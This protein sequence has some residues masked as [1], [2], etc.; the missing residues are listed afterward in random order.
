MQHLSSLLLSQWSSTPAI[1]GTHMGVHRIGYLVRPYHLPHM[2]GFQKPAGVLLRDPSS[3]ISFNNQ[4]KAESPRRQNYFFCVYSE[5]VVMIASS[6]FFGANKKAPCTQVVQDVSCS[7]KQTESTTPLCTRA[8]SSMALPSTVSH[9]S[10][11]ALLLSCLYS[12]KVWVL[13]RKLLM[14]QTPI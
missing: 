4:L 3:L 8:S 10:L 2:L 1:P 6:D 11:T 7:L 13:P 12:K 5:H 9:P 14:R